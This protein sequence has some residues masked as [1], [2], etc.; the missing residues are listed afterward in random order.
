MHWCIFVVLFLESV[1]PPTEDLSIFEQY[2]EY[3]VTSNTNIVQSI[4]KKINDT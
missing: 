2:F 4:L 3:K 1:W